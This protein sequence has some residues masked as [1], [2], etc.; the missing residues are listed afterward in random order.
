MFAPTILEFSDENKNYI[1][2]YTQKNND[3]LSQVCKTKMFNDCN[4]LHM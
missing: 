4:I 2:I 1:Y 3:L